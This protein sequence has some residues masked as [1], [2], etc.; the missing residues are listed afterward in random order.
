MALQEGMQEKTR[1]SR[2]RR[3]GKNFPRKSERGKGFSYDSESSGSG[4]SLIN[5]GNRPL[6]VDNNSYCNLIGQY[7]VLSVILTQFKTYE[8]LNVPLKASINGSFSVL[9]FYLTIRLRARVFYEQ[10]VKEAQ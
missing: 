9:N 10:I 3:K 4:L 5:L 1:A 8:S 7:P 6:T 2:R